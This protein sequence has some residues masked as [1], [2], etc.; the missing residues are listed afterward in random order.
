MRC[1]FRFMCLMAAATLLVRGTAGGSVAE[2]EIQWHADPAQA[3]ALAR[4]DGRPL[5]LLLTTDQCY[6]CSKMKLSTYRDRQV[7][8]DI[9]D[10]FV[11]AQIDAKKHPLLTK[12]LG[13]KVYPTTVIISPDYR[14]ID[15]IAGC[16]DAGKLRVRMAAATTR[17]RVAATGQ[18][19]ERSASRY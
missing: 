16:V 5:L 10:H 15:L 17:N 12:K 4:R 14:V 18:P 11:A 6:Y 1:G 8:A 2:S 3:H 9:T 13:V 19:A 7:A